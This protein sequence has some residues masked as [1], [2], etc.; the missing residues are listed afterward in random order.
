MQHALMESAATAPSPNPLHSPPHSPS[1]LASL[2]ESSPPSPPREAPK[3]YSQ[4]MKEREDTPEAQ[5]P[6]QDA[7]LDVELE[8]GANAEVESDEGLSRQRAESPRVK[9][10]DLPWPK[11]LTTII[12]LPDDAE[13]ADEQEPSAEPELTLEQS[14]SDPLLTPSISSSHAPPAPGDS[15]PSKAAFYDACR[16]WGV[17]TCGYAMS[18]YGEGKESVLACCS[19][20]RISDCRVQ[21]SAGRSVEGAWV[22][23]SESYIL[24]H[25]HGSQKPCKRIYHR[26]D[27]P[28]LSPEAD[29]H[30]K[31]DE[32][33][34][35]ELATSDEESLGDASD[36]VKYRYAF[37]GVVPHI[38]GLPAVGDRF[39]RLDELLLRLRIAVVPVTGI[40][41]CQ[42]RISDSI[43]RLVCQHAR[44]S[45]VWGQVCTF[46]VVAEQDVSGSWVVGSNSNY[47]H[48]HGR[49]LRI[50]MDSG[51]RPLIRAFGRYSEAK[52]RRK[53]KQL[54]VASRRKAIAKA[55]SRPRESLTSTRAHSSLPSPPPRRLRSNSE[56]P[57]TT[58]SSPSPAKRSAIVQRQS[59]ILDLPAS[60]V[61]HSTARKRAP[62]TPLSSSSAFDKRARLSLAPPR[63]PSPPPSP[64][65]FFSTLK[66][67]LTALHPSLASSAALLDL[68]GIRDRSLLVMFVALEEETRQRML[69]DLEM[70]L[71]QRHLLKAGMRR[72]LKGSAG[73]AMAAEG[74]T[75]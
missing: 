53:L 20:R 42:E 45:S 62:S 8:L 7:M 35:D 6:I 75:A 56:R 24:Q 31:E 32:D 48:S 2:L 18:R 38:P 73:S 69:V 39:A 36:E 16:A 22:V 28:S 1:R 41:V 47:K 63:L 54:E 61:A 65:S 15:F 72:M 4:S 34:S 40:N 50:I 68:G 71:L 59:F 37:P 19:R 21:I 26:R 52:D 25:N 55:S 11:R 9:E 44:P 43:Y 51:W 27:Y 60:P 70:P 58:P 13:G 12:E 23:T 66:T 5:P 14:T 3:T 46:A 10:Q 30:D 33:E 17:A 67:F 57:S 64:S 29:E 49:D 74:V